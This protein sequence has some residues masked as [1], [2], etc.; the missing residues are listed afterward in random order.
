MSAAQQPDLA[1]DICRVV[2]M[3]DAALLSRGLPLYSRV[4]AENALKTADF[5]Q[6]VHERGIGLL[7]A[8]IWRM[9]IAL[10]AT[11]RDVLAVRELLAQGRHGEAEHA[12]FAVLPEL[13]A[14]AHNLKSS[15]LPAGVASLEAARKRRDGAR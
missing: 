1:A 9:R 6:A 11:L 3:V 2:E 15:A 4:V 12:I 14:H 8:E 5:E 13:R 7:K 10:A